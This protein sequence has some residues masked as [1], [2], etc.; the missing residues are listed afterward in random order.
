MGRP[1]SRVKGIDVEGQVDRVLGTNPVDDL[2][3]DAIGTDGVDLPRLHNLKAAVA[4]VVVVT[5]TREGGADTSVDVG[6]V[7]EQTLLGSMVEV[8]AVVDRGDLGGRAAKD[9][10]LPYKTRPLSI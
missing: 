7:A 5:G 6:V 2:L 3:D 1:T 8:G 10:G 4:V 9:L